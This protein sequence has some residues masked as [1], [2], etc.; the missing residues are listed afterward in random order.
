MKGAYWWIA[1]WIVSVMIITWDRMHVDEDSHLYVAHCQHEQ[2][3]SPDQKNTADH[4]GM[5]IC[6]GCHTY[7]VVEQDSEEDLPLT[8]LREEGI[9]FEDSFFYG[10]DIAVNIWRPPEL[11]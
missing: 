11:G 2:P 10:K 3:D 6:V 1:L 4:C 8:S 7:V 9:Y 5:C